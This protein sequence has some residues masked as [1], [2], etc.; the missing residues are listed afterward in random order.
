MCRVEFETRRVRGPPEQ[1]CLATWMGG[2]RLGHQDVPRPIKR[3]DGSRVD[4]NLG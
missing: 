3:V 4:Q 2:Q 1:F